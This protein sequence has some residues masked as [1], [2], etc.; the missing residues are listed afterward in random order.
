MPRSVTRAYRPEMINDSPPIHHEGIAL[1]HQ[2]PSNFLNSVAYHTHVRQYSELS[3]FG[4]TF[5]GTRARLPTDG[6][7]VTSAS[8]DRLNQLHLGLSSQWITVYTYLISP[9]TSIPGR[10]I[11][12]KHQRQLQYGLHISCRKIRTNPL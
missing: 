7:D 5:I 2:S 8:D 11:N 10:K 6:K 3:S 1:H 12:N 9:A 4:C